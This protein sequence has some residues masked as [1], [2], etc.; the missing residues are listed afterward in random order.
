MANVPQASSI[1]VVPGIRLDVKSPA[2]VT[3]SPSYF[4][5]VP[6]AENLA[7][8][9]V[10]TAYSETI[11]AQGGTSPYAFSLAP[12][13]SL[14]SG[15]SMSTG[16]VISG[17]PTTVQTATFTVKVTDTNGYTGSQVF[18]ITISAPVHNGSSYVWLT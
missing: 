6:V 13:S 4:N 16:G 18:Q 5:P 11:S 1:S 9:T 7:G 14:P 15:L 17:T 3:S 12:G 8:G 2:P 10:G